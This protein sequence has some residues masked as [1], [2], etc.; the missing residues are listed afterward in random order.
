M[1]PAVAVAPAEESSAAAWMQTAG[2]VGLVTLLMWSPLA[3]G[4]TESWSQF[5]QRTVVV[6]LLGMWVVLQYLQT[7]IELGP[8]PT[9]L[10]ALLFAGF[11]ALQF[12]GG[13][14][15]YRYAT[16]SEFLNIAVYGG[17]ILLAG[18][19]LYSRRCS[20]KFVFA[21][22]VFGFALALLALFQGLSG[23][24]KIFWLRA[25]HD[26]A[27]DIYGPYANHNHYAGLM[28]MLVPLAAAA[29]LLETGGKR[30]I[31]LF[32][33][34][35][36]A[37]SLVFSR[38]RGG[39]IGLAAGFL[40]VCVM[41]F[42]YQRSRR[43][44]FG[45]G[46]FVAI[47]AAMVLWLGT[48]RIMERLTEVQD[49]YRLSIYGDC[50]RMWLHKPMMGFGLGTFSTVYPQFRSFPTNLFVNHAHNDYLEL[51]VETGLVGPALVV[52]FLFGVFRNGFAKMRDAADSEGRLLTLALLT[53]IVAILVH[54]L[55][56]FNLHIPANAALFFV[57]C[58]AAAT[59][60]RRRIR[61]VDLT[62]YHDDDGVSV[63]G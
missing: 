63:E 51:M 29:A 19:T 5:I 8:N 6:A 49:N 38:S 36:M 3:F 53:G 23:T 57:L 37:L 52:W 13:V 20:R 1:P 61:P 50:V 60:F 56:D 22:A 40:F 25:T 46:I 62:A 27:A 26:A 34:L 12:L 32:A 35:T 43:G 17:L 41:L 47:V 39:M 14:S 59:P 15:S 58:A 18:E 16:L 10:P 45:I 2:F 7:A 28:E 30:M 21:M 9:Y 55:L 54:S 48:D 42:R 33:T 31:L 11:I 24:N 44:L 4:T